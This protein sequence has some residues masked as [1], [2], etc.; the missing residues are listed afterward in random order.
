LLHG[1]SERCAQDAVDVPA[2]SRRQTTVFTVA[3]A[4][5]RPSIVRALDVYRGELRQL[6]AANRRNKEAVDEL[7]IAC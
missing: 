3:S 5:G 2:G 6:Q 1:S 4:A 7:G